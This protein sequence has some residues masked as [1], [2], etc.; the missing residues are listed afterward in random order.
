MGLTEEE[1]AVSAAFLAPV[2]AFLDGTPV[3]WG[4]AEAGED[5]RV[6]SAS[7]E[8]VVEKD[9]RKAAMAGLVEALRELALETPGGEA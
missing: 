2:Q 6:V 7:G 3:A 8:I 5:L 4:G 9:E 1:L